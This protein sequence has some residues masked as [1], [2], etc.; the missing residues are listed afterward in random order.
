MI[1]ALPHVQTPARL[2]GAFWFALQTRYQC[3]RKIT[4]QL[5]EKSIFNFLPLTS[6]VHRW[7]DRTKRI[8]S[9][10]FPGYV[11]VHLVPR[12]ETRLA[13]LKTS[14]V[15]RFVGTSTEPVPIP[16]KQIEDLRLVLSN[17]VPFAEHPFLVA[18]QRVRIR[19][20]CLHGVEGI[21]KSVQ[22]NR[23]VV[24]SIEPIQRSIVVSLKDYSVEPV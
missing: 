17:R 7:S 13:V 3:E 19:G 4:A 15:I 21:W 6:A 14:G 18:G 1:D 10:L 5:E 9:P 20:G 22:Q 8:E 16:E 23:S 11:F 12:H 2:P 24:I